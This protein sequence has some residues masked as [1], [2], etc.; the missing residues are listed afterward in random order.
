MTTRAALTLAAFQG[1][2]SVAVA[3]VISAQGFLLV[4]EAM[5]NQ[6]S[7]LGME[8]NIHN[9]RAEAVIIRD[10]RKSIISG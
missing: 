5:E 4:T 3:R 8:L 6:K 7:K 10:E 9:K 2:P 1:C